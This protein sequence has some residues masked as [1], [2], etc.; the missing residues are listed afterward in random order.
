MLHH[1]FLNHHE[2]SSR[3]KKISAG[4]GCPWHFTFQSDFEESNRTSSTQSSWSA[5]PTS[6]CCGSEE[7][8]HPQLQESN[9]WATR[10]FTNAWVFF[11]GVRKFLCWCVEKS[12]PRTLLVDLSE[13]CHLVWWSVCNWKTYPWI[14]LVKLCFQRATTPRRPTEAIPEKSM[15]VSSTHKFRIGREE[16]F[17]RVWCSRKLVNC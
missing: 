12:K 5:S 15:V 4:V 14:R 3:S 2:R 17:L 16:H 8:E 1:L 6:H 9:R 11:P 7:R 13:T 10:E